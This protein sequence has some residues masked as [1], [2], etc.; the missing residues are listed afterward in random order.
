MH[1]ILH[2]RGNEDRKI[3]TAAIL[4][5]LEQP[6]AGTGQDSDESVKE[7]QN[8]PVHLPRRILQSAVD[9]FSESDNED[10]A[11]LVSPPL[12]STSTTKQVKR[13][14]QEIKWTHDENRYVIFHIFQ[15]LGFFSFLNYID[16]FI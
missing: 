2:L 4:P 11:L 8:N 12:P 3:R 16:I 9:I 7:E 13:G 14:R 1:I 15:V 10:D 5:P 6:E